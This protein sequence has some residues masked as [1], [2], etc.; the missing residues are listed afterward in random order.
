MHTRAPEPERLDSGAQRPPALQLAAKSRRSLLLGSLGALSA[1]ALLRP[2]RSSAAAPDRLRRFERAK[3]GRSLAP[4]PAH[5]PAPVGGS[6]ARFEI[7]V[8][9]RTIEIAP[10]VRFRAWTFNGTVPGPVLH[11]RQGQPVEIT[12]HNRGNMAHSFDLHAARVA[13][14]TTFRDIPPGKSMTI[15]FTAHDPGVFVYHCVTSPAVM[16]IAM[17]MYG[18]MV[19]TPSKPLPQADHQFVLV[20][21]EWYL[22]GSGQDKPADLDFDKALDMRPDVVTFNGV[23]SQYVDHA[24]HVAPGKLARFYVG[25]AGPNLA[26]PFHVVGTVF[27]RVYLDGDVTTWLSGVQTTSVAPGAGAIFDVRFDQPGANGFVNHA[28]ANAHKGAQGTI[29]V[30]DATGRMTH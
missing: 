28:F 2:S 14:G 25:N 8:E 23:A 17:G 11:V 16:H 3:G 22:Y 20:G 10:G 15:S 1:G 30:G 6:V 5:L 18:A 24:L 13:A 19:V 9:D 4:F 27:E 7:T 21:S 26:I 29:L 12:F